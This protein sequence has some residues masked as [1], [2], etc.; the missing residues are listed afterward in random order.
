MNK[1]LREIAPEASCVSSNI[2]SADSSA[3]TL[4]RRAPPVH[5]EPFAVEKTCVSALTL[6]AAG[7]GLALFAELRTIVK[8]I[9]DRK[10][11][12]REASAHC[13]HVDR[14]LSRLTAAADNISSTVGTSSDALPHGL[15]QNFVDTLPTVNDTLRRADR[16]VSEYCKEACFGGINVGRESFANKCRRFLRLKSLNASMTS[17]ER[18]AS[19]AEGKL[20]HL[21]TQLCASLK[22]DDL[23][24]FIQEH[25]MP[26][27]KFR[28]AFNAPLLAGNI[29]LDFE[30]KDANGNYFAPEGSLKS[31]VFISTG[32]RHVTVARGARLKSGRHNPVHGVSGMAGVGKTVALIGLGH[33]ED[34]Q[35]HFTDGVL[36]MSIGA[37]ATLGHVI[38]ELWKIMSVTGATTSAQAVKSSKSLAD[39]I[40]VA[41]VWF[42]GKRLL[43]LI[44]DIWPS[45]TN[46]E[47]YLAD[48]QG[49][50]QGSPDSRMALSTRSVEIAKKGGSHVDFGARDHCGPTS[51]AIFL[52]HALPDIQPTD[53]LLDSSRSVLVLCA[54]LPI[55][56]SIAGAAVALCMSSEDDFDDACQTYLKN[57]QTQISLHPGKSFLDNAIQ[58]S[59]AALEEYR[60]RNELVGNEGYQ[61]ALSELYVSLCVLETQQFAP[62]SVLAKMWGVSES[63]ADNVCVSFKSMSMAKISTQTLDGRKQRGVSIHDLY[64]QFCRQSASQSGDEQAW[65][66]RLL[67]GHL[68]LD[69][70]LNETVEG[71]DSALGVNMLHH[72]PRPWWTEDIANKEYVRKHISRHL[73]SAGL[74]LELGSTVLDIRWLCAQGQAG[75]ALDLLNDLDVL[76]ASCADISQ[77]VV[78]VKLLAQLITSMASLLSD[79]I[80]VIYHYMSGILFG[81]G[82]TD[83]WVHLFLERA[84]AEVPKPFLEPSVA[85]FRYP[86]EDL[87][88]CINLRVPNQEGFSYLSTDFS[89]CGRYCAAGC[90]QDIVVFDLESQTRLKWL[91]GHQKDVTAV[92]FTSDLGTLISGSL[93]LTIIVWHWRETESP[94][95]VLRGHPGPVTCLSVHGKDFRF[96]SGSRDGA[97][98]MWDATLGSLCHELEIGADVECVSICSSSELVAIGTRDGRLLC[99]DWISEQ[100]VYEYTFPAKCAI[101]AVQ[102]SNDGKVLVCGTAEGSATV[103]QCSEWKKGVSVKVPGSLTHIAFHSDGVNSVLGSSTGE[104]RH[105][106][107]SEDE[108]SKYNIALGRPVNGLSFRKNRGEIVL[109]NTLGVADAYRDPITSPDVDFSDARNNILFDFSLS[110]DGNRVATSTHDSMIRLWSCNTG[111]VIAAYGPPDG[112]SHCLTLSADGFKLAS[113][114]PIGTVT[115][116]NAELPPAEGDLSLSVDAED[117]GCLSF[118]PDESKLLVCVEQKIQ[119][120]SVGIR[121]K[122]QEVSVVL[123]LHGSFSSDGRF[124]IAGNAKQTTVWDSATMETVFDSDKPSSSRI[125]TTEAMH[126]M[127]TCG[128]YAH[129]LCHPSLRSTGV[130]SS[131]LTVDNIFNFAGSWVWSSDMAFCKKTFVMKWASRMVICKLQE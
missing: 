20:Q 3:P 17:I 47:G 73:R 11:L 97:V 85:V 116:W 77:E 9:Q 31:C 33:D 78:P 35:N 25:V 75:G 66:Q 101:T 55:S 28:P 50:L 128:S 6:D 64:L 83:E 122:I 95:F 74:N 32:P 49:L 44:D 13:I 69:P 43:F 123:S 36:Y 27:E 5:L 8:G 72:T 87:K 119:I 117:I 65:H 103:W 94:S 62:I 81:I 63:F 89:S 48:L 22:V 76:R 14:I 10:A 53:H 70:L 91:K 107:V 98:K 4:E 61:H 111:S 7:L 52:A 127:K 67:S 130:A 102:F 93:D 12:Y 60:E 106:N 16:S 37:N 120:W 115:I 86:V 121:Q 29:H 58:L 88:L 23:K 124:I 118:S 21:C 82:E 34:I 96:C 54:G 104:I 100:F 59:L 41:S 90:N 109:G 68:P 110:N 108:I 129:R 80:R 112:G 30:S 79:G 51:L 38:T 105:W 1:H 114:S 57:I 126:L 131:P 24:E 2:Y 92:R 46:P 125:S 15:R 42:H 39:A 18:E 113:A 84:K 19:D 56:L 45:E 26:S 99:S 40:A 71:R